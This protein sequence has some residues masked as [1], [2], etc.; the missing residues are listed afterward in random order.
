MENTPFQQLRVVLPLIGA[1]S[2]CTFW[3]LFEILPEHVSD[4]RWLLL[5][6]AFA[7]AYSAFLLVSVGPLSLR[8]AALQ[9]AWVSALASLLM[10]SSSWR[11][12]SLEDALDAGHPFAAYALLTSLPIPF[13]LAFETAPKG[14]RDYEALFDNAWSIFVRSATAWAFTGL[15][16]LV[17]FLS[18]ALLGLVGFNY[19]GDLISHALVWMSLTGLVLGLALSV[20]D[21]MTGVVS[22][23]RGLA[24]QLLR[25]LLPLVAVVVALF[26][27]QVPFQGLARVFGSLSAAATMLAMVA[28]AATLITAAVEASD[29]DAAKSRLMVGTARGLSLLL[30]IVAGIAVYAIWLRV[31]QYGW[32]PARLG[33]TLVALVV[34]GYA[35][36]Y[37]A[38]V[39]SGAAWRALIRSAN[40]YIALSIIGL[41]ILW[42]SPIL[43]AERIS[44]NG[45]VARF[46]NGKIAVKDLEFHKL[47]QTWGKAGKR[48][49][50]RLRS[51]ENPPEATVLAAALK[52]FDQG[53]SDSELRRVTQKG[54]RETALAALAAEMPLHPRGTDWP[55]GALSSLSDRRLANVLAGCRQLLETGQSGCVAIALK[56]EAGQLRDSLMVFY[57]GDATEQV[58]YFALVANENSDGYRYSTARRL[59]AGDILDIESTALIAALH[60]GEFTVAPAK[61]NAIELNGMQILARP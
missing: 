30:P 11:F 51:A 22:T 32:T 10:F 44:A 35:L 36:S 2:G 45:H 38:A 60:A 8:R 21:E 24:L 43:N 13:I 28:G 1:I 42:F 12:F 59:I 34:L 7:A 57:R 14:W 41:S 26:I 47:D 37:A 48:A 33:G 16:W 54:D 23:M 15:F 29:E 3:L 49:L 20:L 25:L 6:A 9:G 61:L 55:N 40:T 4:A 5:L 58:Q 17:V 50:E 56:V 19:I 31:A 52:S 53:A 18:D 46:L 27:V 39:L